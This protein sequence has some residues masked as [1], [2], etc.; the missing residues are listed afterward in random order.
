MTEIEQ[1]AAELRTELDRHNQLYY[2]HNRPEISDREFDALMAELIQLETD[3]PQLQRADSPTQRV[4]GA[5]VDGFESVRHDPPMLSLDNSYDA[6]ELDEWIAR[7]GRQA[8]G[9]ELSYVAELKIDGVSISLRYVDRVLTQAVTRGN[10]EVGDD[11]TV[12]VRTIRNLP[13]RLPEDAPAE[14]LLRG[15]IFMPRDVFQRLNRE[16][17]ARGEALYANPRNTTAG[18][19]R[20]LDSREVSRR[21]LAV[22]VFA[23]ANDLG[24]GS[25]GETLE[26]LKAWGLPVADSWRRCADGAA[27]QAFIEHWGTERHGLSFETDGVVIKVDSLALHD[28][29]GRTG[30]APRWAIAYKFEAEQAQ[31]RVLGI[32]VQ[33]GRTGVLTP[34]AELEPVLLAGTTVKRA[35]LHNYEDLARKDVRVGDLV[36]VEKGGDIIP[37]VLGAVLEARPPGALPYVMPTICPVPACGQAVS[38]FEGEVAVRCVNVACSAVVAQSIGHFVSRNAM[39]IE[40]LGSKSIEL[41]LREKLVSDYTSLYELR[42]DDLSGLD[43]W[44]QKSAENVLEQIEA[45]KQRPLARLLFAIGIRFVGVGV[46]RVLAERFRDLDGLMKAE[47]ED[48]E[49]TPE[50][51]PKVADSVLRFFADSSNRERL[52]KLRSYGLRL[53]QPAPD[54]VPDVADSPFAGKTVVLTGTLSMPRSAAKKRLEAAGAKVT[55]SVSK[56]TDLVVAGESAGSKLEKAQKLGVEVIDDAG[57]SELL[58]ALDA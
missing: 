51:G 40:G 32:G 26:Q 45:S 9:V 47:R 15:E 57:F 2:V 4:G 1:R 44:G 31:T 14:V 11:I 53:D 30:K 36:R 39:D 18:T 3:H 6:E 16:R 29:L 58:A 54:A 52:D 42:F 50:I 5:P 49:D 35:T 22:T 20:L 8:P 7:L 25:H 23:A 48:L 55:G 41:L 24:L 13:L 38:R 34:V 28:Q 56:K 12:N 27:L 33:V 46:A 10:G 17:E 19:I 37:K 43:G 21:N